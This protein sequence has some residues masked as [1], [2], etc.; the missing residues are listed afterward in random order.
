MKEEVSDIQNKTSENNFKV[1]APFDHGITYEL[2]A[3]TVDCQATTE[4]TDIMEKAEKLVNEKLGYSVTSDKLQ[5][6]Y[7]SNHVGHSGERS[8]V[9]FATVEDKDM[10]QQSTEINAEM[11]KEEDYFE[12]YY[13]PRNEAK[14]FAAGDEFV[15]N[16]KVIASLL[17][18][19]CHFE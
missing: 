16:S 18:Y 14:A 10:I 19:F 2:C 8:T 12:I 1:V 9:L 11:S 5:R 7:Q 4:L 3:G 6:I 13:L 17:W 15:K